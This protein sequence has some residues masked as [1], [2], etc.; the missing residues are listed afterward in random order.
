MSILY[1]LDVLLRFCFAS[2]LFLSD[3]LTFNNIPFGV[4][5]FYIYINLWTSNH[6]QD[7][8]IY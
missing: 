4:M 3:P 5:N 2:F 8:K 7:I 6:R 1:K